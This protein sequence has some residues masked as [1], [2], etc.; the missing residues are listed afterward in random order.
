MSRELLL[1]LGVGV[2]LAAAGVWIAFQTHWESITVPSPM[3]G[4]ALR[5][6]YYALEHFAASLGLDTEEVSGMRD[7]A[8]NAVLVLAEPGD[9]HTR[10]PV[11]SLENWVEAGGRLVLGADL[12]N[13]YPALK[14]WSGVKTAEHL[15]VPAQA[16]PNPSVKAPPSQAARHEPP[17]PHADAACPL[18]AESADGTPTGQ[19]FRV[20]QTGPVLRFEGDRAP[21]WS[22][23]DDQGMRVIRTGMGLGEITVLGSSSMLTNEMLKRA[24]HAEM[25]AAAAGLRHADRLLIFHPPKAQ[26]LLGLLWRLAAPGMS[27]LLA[28]L[29]AVAWRHGPRFGPPLPV[30]TPL[31]RS[32]AE[33]IRAS[34]RF[35]WRTRRLQG[36]HASTR[37]ALDDTAARH[38]A[39]YAALDDSLRSERLAAYTG[40]DAAAIRAART[41][42]PSSRP[43]EERAAITLMEVCRRI[44]L[45]MRSA[46]QRPPV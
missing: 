27:F 18:L 39:G 33:Q 11:E 26:P 31:R 1:K 37:H 17:R 43:N 21:A 23:S 2:L 30:P 15:R 14:T 7:L 45:R 22:L 32:L 24:D 44:L 46:H 19:S 41:A 40:L 25:L 34:A 38:I 5:N 42:G 10:P 20:C 28:S 3:K 8:L 9:A 36:L 16:A 29:L 13:S 12:L 6:P 35:A 4:E